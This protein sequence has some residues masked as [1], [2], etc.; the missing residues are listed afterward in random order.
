MMTTFSASRNPPAP[1]RGFDPLAG[2]WLD[3]VIAAI[4]V[5][6][7]FVTPLQMLRLATALPESVNL[8]VAGVFCLAAT[9]VAWFFCAGLSRLSESLA[10]GISRLPLTAWIVIGL[11]LRLAW[12][13]LFPATPGS[14]GAA[15]LSLAQSWMDTG[16]YYA[17]NCF[18]YW[19]VGYP[20]FLTFWLRLCPSA[21]VAIL[22]ANLFLF[23]L[24]ACGVGRLTRLLAGAEAERVA[25]A[26]FA[27][28]PNLIANSATPEKETLV[29]ALLPWAAA[30][31]YRAL[32]QRRASSALAGGALLGMAT[33][34]QPSLQF[35]PFLGAGVLFAVFMRRKGAL[36]LPLALLLG[37]AVVV[38]PWT[39]RNYR[40]FDRF[41]LVATNGGSNLY[42]ANNPLAT[43]G[44]TERGEVDLSG[45]SEIEE[46]RMGRK[47]AV[48]WILGHPANFGALALEKLI[49]FMGDDAGG[50]YAT[51]KVGKA[52]DDGR[53]YAAC[54]AAAN[55]WWMAV[56]FALAALVFFRWRKGEAR[57][58]PALLVTWFWL[59]L[60]VLHAVFE[61][62]GKYHVPML[63]APCVLLAALVCATDRRGAA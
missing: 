9:A 2:A 60:L 62:A 25:A 5:M 58:R 1:F 38:A 39:I 54:K 16:Q 50:V 48:E 31:L 36:L 41:V 33:L 32:T 26:L 44:Y 57:G 12:I 15:Y 46:D 3:K 37:A 21:S 29:V 30:F 28:W 43:G 22:A 10:K 45:L 63:W 24:G 53:L 27:L 56:W 4:A 13:A 18:A 14:D 42:R 6:A 61:S 49:R 11:A 59:Y 47:L 8:T 34:V 52:S 20:L 23:A 40:V 51:F 35:I 19:P 55:G 7:L 17:E